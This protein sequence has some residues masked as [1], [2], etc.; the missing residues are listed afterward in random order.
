M[1]TDRLCSAWRVLLGHFRGPSADKPLAQLRE[2]H[3]PQ[4]LRK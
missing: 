4:D 2:I 3:L 1:I